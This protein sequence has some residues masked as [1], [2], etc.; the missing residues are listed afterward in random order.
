M[1]PKGYLRLFPG[2]EVR[3]RGVGFV[4]N[5]PASTRM[6]TA[7]DREVHCTLVPD[8]QV[9]HAAARTARSRATSTGSARST[10][11][12]AEVRL[13]DRLFS[14]RRSG[15]RR[16]RQDLRRPSEP[17]F[18]A[19]R[20]RLARAGARRR[21]RRNSTSSSSATAISSPTATTT[22]RQA[23]VQPRRHP[24]RF[25][26]QGITNHRSPVSSSIRCPPLG[27][28]SDGSPLARND[29]ARDR[30]G[31]RSAPANFL[32]IPPRDLAR[33][34]AGTSHTPLPLT[35]AADFP[36]TRSPA[37]RPNDALE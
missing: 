33:P 20:A 18:Q 7:I 8:T 3:L 12:A 9:G 35:S 10:R 36:A 37:L 19:R 29:W 11:I 1:P 13:Y 5:A 22:A 21:R 14:V 2:G 30:R 4:S 31:S 15:R 28:R 17:G 23:G 27:R 16:R 32:P 6:T 24:A 34:A 26:G 25:V